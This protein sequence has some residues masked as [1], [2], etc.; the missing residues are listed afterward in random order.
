MRAVVLA[1]SLVTLVALPARADDWLSLA[2]PVRQVVLDYDE[3]S[4]T[5]SL[6][7]PLGRTSVRLG[8][9][10]ALQLPEY[11]PPGGFW[12]DQHT[13][14]ATELNDLEFDFDNETAIS[15]TIA[16]AW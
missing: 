16:F 5:T 7:V 15:L 4:L 2:E 11:E 13:L 14:L 10:N 8:I 3:E 9:V 6:M 12:L 1:L